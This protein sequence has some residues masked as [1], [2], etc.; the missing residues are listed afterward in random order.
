LAVSALAP[1]LK[2]IVDAGDDS[3]AVAAHQSVEPTVA[4]GG[5]DEKLFEWDA[6]NLALTLHRLYAWLRYQRA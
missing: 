5:G 6:A 3:A 4:S 2:A 1:A